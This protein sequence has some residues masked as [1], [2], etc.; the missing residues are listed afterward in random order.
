MSPRR[1]RGFTLI[2]LLVVIA[3]IGVLIALLL[4]AVQQARESARRSQ[5]TNNLKQIGLAFHN[6]MD[7]HKVLPPARFSTIAGNTTQG[8]N[9]AAIV[10]L[11]PNLEKSE[12]YQAINFS[13]PCED[14]T[15]PGVN[16][17]NGTVR[18]TTVGG[19]LCPSDGTNPLPARGGGV[20]YWANIGSGHVWMWPL[21]PPANAALP[22]PSGTMF[23]DSRIKPGQ[24]S[25]GLS[26][27]A[28]MSERLIG[29]GSNSIITLAS[30]IFL[31]TTMPTTPDEAYQHCKQIDTSNLA[32]Q[33]PFFMGAPWIHGQHAYMHVSPPNAISCGYLSSL[34]STMP[35]SSKH[36]GGVNLLLCDGSVTFYTDSIDLSVWRATGTRAGGET[37]ENRAGAY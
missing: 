13:M 6:Y 15:N 37:A 8:M 29:D 22:P 26:R 12:L 31:G 24:I 32:L 18:M 36:P 2:E 35:A 28:L 34:R 23:L 4:P 3:I 21:G 10:Y 7:V 30:D 5:C 27:T 20:N 11:L 19:F 25:D 9:F 17:I 14:T 16:A 1:H 33:F